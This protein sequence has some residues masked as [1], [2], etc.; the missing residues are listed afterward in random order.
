MFSIIDVVND[1]FD[2]IN[3]KKF[4]CAIALDQGSATCGSG[5]ASG[6][7]ILPLRLSV[8]IKK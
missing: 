1:C 4:S 6:S 2:N 8:A 5:A 7:L 3:D